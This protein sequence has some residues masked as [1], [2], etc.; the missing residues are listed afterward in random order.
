MLTQTRPIYTVQ[1]LD[2]AV[3]LVKLSPRV[4]VIRNTQTG[5]DVTYLGFDSLDLAQVCRDWMVGHGVGHYD[6]ATHSGS[7]KP[8]KSTRLT[9][10]YELKVH[11]MPEA[12]IAR[13][14]KKDQDRDLMDRAAAARADLGI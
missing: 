7:N 10:P 2:T 1:P 13:F 8:R 14:V 6:R 9:T 3:I 4:A 5:H 12:L 11:A